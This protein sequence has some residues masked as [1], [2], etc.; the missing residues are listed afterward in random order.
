MDL[1]YHAE[2]I[3]QLLPNSSSLAAPVLVFSN[4]YKCPGSSPLG[5]A[6]ESR[7]TSITAAVPAAASDEW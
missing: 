7:A 5:P 2:K 3:Y 4:F 1:V 6:A